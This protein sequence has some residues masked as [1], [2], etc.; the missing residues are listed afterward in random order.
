MTGIEKELVES[1]KKGNQ[2]SFELVF[3]TY[4]TRLCTYAFDY[5]RQLETAEDLVKDFFL[6]LWQNREKIEIKTSLSGYL[7]R[8]VHNL[9][10][11][12]LERQKKKNPEIPS[13]NLYLIELKQKQPFTPDYPIGNLLASEME[14]QILEIVDKLP[15]QCREIFKLSR[16][17]E[18][19]H[20]KIAEK[21]NISERTVKTQIYR[22]LKKIKEAIPFLITTIF[23]YFLK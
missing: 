6:N 10:L 11:N 1:L 8:S 15:E 7:F 3:K 2:K 16:F 23:F 21:L 20:K 22:A 17:E 9:C 4:Y 18:L 14:G 19:P 12:Y 13:D 5:T